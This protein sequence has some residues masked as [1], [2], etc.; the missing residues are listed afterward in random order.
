MKLTGTAMSHSFD[1]VM[2]NLPIIGKSARYGNTGCG[3]F[4][5]GIQNHLP[6]YTNS[7]NSIISLGYVDFLSKTFANF[8]SFS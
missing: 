6:T 4:K 8:A 2:E 5:G 3:V 7:Q 1:S